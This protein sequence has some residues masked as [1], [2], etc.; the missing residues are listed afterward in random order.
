MFENIH[1]LSTSSLQSDPTTLLKIVQAYA[2]AV[3]KG[4]LKDKLERANDVAESGSTSVMTN[5][6]QRTSEP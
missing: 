3:S 1:T 6:A 4:E 5:K 2:E